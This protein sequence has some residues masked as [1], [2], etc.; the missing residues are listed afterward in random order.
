MVSIPPISVSGK[1]ASRRIR[2][3]HRETRADVLTNDRGSPV[4]AFGAQRS[5]TFTAQTGFANYLPKKTVLSE[6]AGRELKR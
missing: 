6:D 4:I 3:T 1:R 2:I 5:I